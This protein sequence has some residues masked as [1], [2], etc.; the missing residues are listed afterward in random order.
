MAV[1]QAEAAMTMRRVNSRRI[2]I[3]IGL[4][5][6]MIVRPVPAA[7][8]CANLTISQLLKTSTA[9]FTG[10]AV[11]VKPGEHFLETR[12]KI[13]EAFKGTSADKEIWVL[14][15]SVGSETPPKFEAARSYLVFA[16]KH[17]GKLVVAGGCTGTVE[18]RYAK[19]SISELR[20]LTRNRKG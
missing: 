16:Y 4:L 1:E 17:E 18:I 3:A 8:K 19:K 13:S 6:L 20:R 11:E 12:F 9:V 15:Y 7:S 2:G 5:V 14:T 10:E